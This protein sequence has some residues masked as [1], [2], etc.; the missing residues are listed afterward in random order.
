MSDHRLKHP[1]TEQIYQALD[2]LQQAKDHIQKAI[3]E[4]PALI[5]DNL[6]LRQAVISNLY[7]FEEDIKPSWLAHVFGIS[8]GQ[9]VGRIAGEATA[10]GP[11]RDCNQRFEFKVTSRSSLNDRYRRCDACQEKWDLKHSHSNSQWLQEYNARQEALKARIT[12]LRTMPYREYL[13]SPEWQERRKQAMKRAGFR[14]QICN[15]YGVRLNVHH[16]TYERRGNEDNRDLITL[17]EDCHA[18]FHENGRL[19]TVEA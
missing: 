7:W 8:N 15:A 1:A 12:E 2:E 3:H 6:E 17:C 16:R 9:K 11:C 19:A 18:T 13:Q 10:T 14:C 5:G 4:L